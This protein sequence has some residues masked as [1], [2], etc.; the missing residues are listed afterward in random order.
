MSCLDKTGKVVKWEFFL[1]VKE[2]LSGKQSKKLSL[3]SQMLM[4]NVVMFVQNF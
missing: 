4:K 3:T 2:F 1:H